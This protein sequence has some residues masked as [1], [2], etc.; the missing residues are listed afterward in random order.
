MKQIHLLFSLFLLC[1]S[2]QTFY[3]QQASTNQFAQAKNLET[4]DIA[5]LLADAENGQTVAS[6][7]SKRSLTPASI[8]KV[9]TTATVLEIFGPDYR[10][11]THLE[12]TGK[13]DSD[14]TL[15]GDIYIR[16][17]GDPTLGSEF[18]GRDK[19]DFLNTCVTLIKQAGIRKIDGRIFADESCFDIEGVSPKWLWE[20]LGNYFASGAYGIS[21]CDNMYRLYFKS[22]KAGTTPEIIRTQP[23]MNIRF[24]NSLTTKSN[25]IDSAYIYGV[26]FS[27]ERWIFGSIPAGQSNFFIKGDIPDPPLYLAT[28]LSS[29]LQSSGISIAY[30]PSTYR[31]S[32]INLES[33]IFNRTILHTSYSPRLIDIIRETNVKSNNHY[34]EH[35]FKLIALS[36]HNQGSFVNA[37]ETVYSFWKE[38]GIDL[39]GLFMYDGSGLSPVNRVS[40]EIMIALLVYMNT[41]SPYSADFYTSLPEAGKEGTVRNFLTKTAL[42]G[43]VRMKSGSITNVQCYAGYLNK[44][45]KRYAFCIMANDYTITRGSLRK[46]MEK[47]MLGW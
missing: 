35:L 14:G 25:N 8:L 39:S 29:A 44:G 28:Q 5:V 27:N 3:A 37:A 32:K 18:L 12:Y 31:L 30:Q 7:D 38:K 15:H 1:F 20:D 33:F 2:A 24:I 4:A 47:M 21:F 26:P 40:P 19:D 16:G 22:G 34:A 10:I 46:A 6:F 23:A 43:N 45:N 36:K 13:I 41:K 11:E 9:I 17:G 42:E